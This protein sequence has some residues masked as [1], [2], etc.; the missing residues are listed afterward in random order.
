MITIVPTPRNSQ[1]SYSP[2]FSCFFLAVI[3]LVVFHLSALQE[4]LHLLAADEHAED[5]Q[6]LQ[7]ERVE[8]IVLYAQPGP[9]EKYHQHADYEHETHGACAP[10]VILKH[11]VY[12]VCHFSL[13]LSNLRTDSSSGNCFRHKLHV[14]CLSFLSK[15]VYYKNVHDDCN[16]TH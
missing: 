11:L 16:V 12:W 14:H 8:H 3:V 6:I 2:I 4:F 13:L 7:L 10:V 15:L 9:D 5:A 1:S